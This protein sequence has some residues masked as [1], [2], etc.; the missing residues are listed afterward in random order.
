MRRLVILTSPVVLI[1]V[2]LALP[3]CGWKEEAENW[4]RTA[5]DYKEQLETANKA[6]DQTR[7]D[8]EEQSEQWRARSTEL[9]KAMVGA[10]TTLDPL[11]IKTIYQDNRDLTAIIQKL[12]AEIASPLP[13]AGVLLLADAQLRLDVVDF[14]GRSVLRAFLDED[15]DPFL[16]YELAAT[17]PALPVPDKIAKEFYDEIFRTFKAGTFMDNFA[18]Q[19]A[20]H[21]FAARRGEID[22][23]YVY[24][25]RK[26]FS[27]YL[28]GGRF[29]TPQGVPRPIFLA[30][31][32]RTPGRHEIRI[33]IEPKTPVWQV[34][35][36]A[37]EVSRDKAERVVKDWQ[38]NPLTTPD[39][40]VIPRM[41]F[42]IRHRPDDQKP[43]NAAVESS[44]HAMSHSSLA[45]RD[46]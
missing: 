32:F 15:T 6:L 5:E 14:K 25:V 26:A 29:E 4:R 8:L 21:S 16:K 46:L 20:E 45:K 37:T 41:V 10:S 22:G 33:Q 1:T 39:P 19:E 2:F 17:E 31:Q 27:D 9:G 12:N 13:Q 34:R 44:P 7:K 36:I 23:R 11:A 3:G 42:W 43:T 18:T 28:K 35:I 30:R 40:K 38:L 24:A